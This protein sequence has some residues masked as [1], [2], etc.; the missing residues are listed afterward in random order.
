MDRFGDKVTCSVAEAHLVVST[1]F[2]QFLPFLI[3]FFSTQIHR[4][5]MDLN[6]DGV[7]SQ[8]EFLAACLRDEEINRSLAMFDNVF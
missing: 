3:N 6:D 4:Q 7:I 5:K 2:A 8:D 1:F